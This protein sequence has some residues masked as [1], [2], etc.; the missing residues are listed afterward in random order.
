VELAV[1]TRTA[2]ADW[3]DEPP[4][5]VMTALAVLEARAE[6]ARKAARRA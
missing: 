3:W 2:P 4:E 6:A 5:T 1:E